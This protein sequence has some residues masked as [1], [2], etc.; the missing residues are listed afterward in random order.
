MAVTRD[1]VQDPTGLRT[2]YAGRGF[3][4]CWPGRLNADYTGD[5][6][7][8]D[9]LKGYA[10]GAIYQNFLATSAA[11]L[12]YVN[13]GTQ[14][15][16]TWVSL[17]GGS[18]ITTLTF[19]PN[20]A[21]ALKAWDGTTA[22]LTFDSRTTTDNVKANLFGGAAPTITAAAGTTYSQVSTT[23]QTITLTGST[24]VT[25]MDGL[26]LYLAAPTVT[27]ASAVT[28]TTL[29]TLY[30]ALPVAGGSVTGTTIYSA[31]FAGQIRV[32]G[33]LS[34]ANSAYDILIPANTAAAL[35]VSN[36]TT[37]I[38][39]F[40]TRNTQTSMAAVT[41]IP[42]PPT[43]ASAASIFLNSAISVPARTITLTGTNTVT[44]MLGVMANLGVPTFTDASAGTITTVSSLHVSAPAAAGGALTI[45]NTRM[46]STSVTDCFLTGAGV[47][48]DTASTRDGKEDI[49]TANPGFITRI[50]DA[51]TPRTW[52]YREDVHGDDLDRERVGIVVDELPGELQPP[53]QK[54]GGVAAGVLASFAMAALKFLRDENSE[55]KR[56][57][58][59]LETLLGH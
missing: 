57:V 56:R 33:N 26:G 21:A 24:G 4:R 30:V 20:T 45:T 15:S 6:V 47:W 35:E 42:S 37:K 43:I 22:F 7:P 58:A 23:A 52:K 38:M 44:S 28:V 41:V 54:S 14:T 53:G 18:G 34:M 48:T 19:A 1:D 25:A 36:G 27:D 2:Y 12:L 16:S 50:L 46:I 10:K 55:L 11:T 51:I 8:V 3:L 39:A 32:D 13:S 29:S 5:G 17:T 49:E 31:T 59:K 40:D 9:G